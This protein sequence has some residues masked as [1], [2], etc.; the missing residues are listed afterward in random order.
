MAQNGELT[1]NQLKA[2][3]ALLTEPTI[4]RAADRA[5]LGHR[6]VTRYLADPAFKAELRKRQAE[7]LSAAVAAMLGGV[8]DALATVHK[9]LRDPDA[10]ISELLRAAD[11]WLDHSQKT[12]V[13]DS[14]LERLE[15][16]EADSYGKR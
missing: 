3:E 11:I 7:A 1:R 6:T 15:A 13:T 8:G 5:Q 4:Q 12:A 16:L 10:S 14:I 2:I 9:V